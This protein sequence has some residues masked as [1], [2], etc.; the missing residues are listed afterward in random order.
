MAN[1]LRNVYNDV[2]SFRPHIAAECWSKLG[3]QDDIDVNHW[4]KADDRFKSQTKTIG[5]QINGQRRAEIE[6]DLKT[7]EDQ[8]VELALEI[9]AVKKPH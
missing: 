7:T 8:A 5:I 4:P 1:R 9:P 2:G 3:N 6:L